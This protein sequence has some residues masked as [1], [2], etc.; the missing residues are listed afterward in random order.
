MFASKTA[1]NG[2]NTNSFTKQRKMKNVKNNFYKIGSQLCKN[3]RAPKVVIQFCVCKWG[4][5]RNKEYV[6][7]YSF[8]KTSIYKP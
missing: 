7:T 6:K 3:G 4:A 1:L 2:G 8:T 5:T